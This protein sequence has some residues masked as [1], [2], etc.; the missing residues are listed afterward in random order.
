M[1]DPSKLLM[2]FKFEDHSFASGQ[3]GFF[4]NGAQEMN[5]DLFKIVPQEVYIEPELDL[6]T[7]YIPT[8]CNRYVEIYHGKSVYNYYD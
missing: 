3:V 6:S 5:F 4:T 8:T 2:S 1:D 7:K